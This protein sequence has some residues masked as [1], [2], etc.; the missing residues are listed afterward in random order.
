M[1]TIE[2]AR[3]IDEVA[4]DGFTLVPSVLAPARIT[5]LIDALEELE[6]HTAIREKSGSTYAVRRLCETVPAVRQL[7]DSPELR[8]L[9]EPFLGPAARVVRSLLFDKNPAAN[10]KV[11]W[12]QDL[13]IA[14]K[15]RREVRGF[16]PWSVKA[17]VPHVQP[18]VHVLAGMLT[19][20]LHLD[21]CG[22]DNGPLRV[23]P[24]SHKL[25]VIDTATIAQLRQQTPETSC[26]LAAGGAVLM[27]PLLLHASSPAT[28]PGHR[29]VIHLE[30]AAADLVGGLEWRES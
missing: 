7:A 21:D 10:W 3:P 23:L 4:R 27:R 30:F 5:A 18:P 28:V 22:Q 26:T 24:G 6:S 14:V 19:V 13:T 17:G 9:V 29:R 2:R 1:L 25:G 11:P 15:D 16:G 8:A 12:H 20:R